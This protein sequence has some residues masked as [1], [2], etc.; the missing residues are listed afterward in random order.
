MSDSDH[1]P[2]FPE[3]SVLLSTTTA[4]IIPPSNV[5]V[6]GRFAVVVNE[7]VTFD[8]ICTNAQGHMIISDA[9]NVCLR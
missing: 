3:N 9:E 7:I 4:C 5:I 6:G 2:D 1:L 8:D